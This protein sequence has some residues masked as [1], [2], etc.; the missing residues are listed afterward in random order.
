MKS[1]SSD[2]VSIH[3]VLAAS[4]LAGSAAAAAGATSIS[5]SSERAWQPRSFLVMGVSSSSAG[6]V[7]QRGA[8]MTHQTGDD[9]RSGEAE[10]LPGV[11]D[12]N[13]PSRRLVGCPATEQVPQLDC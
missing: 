9:K 10:Q 4:T 13:L 2:D 3:A 5:N 11:I 12:Q 8:I 6:H 1:T 7:H